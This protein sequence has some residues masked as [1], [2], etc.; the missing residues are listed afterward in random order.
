M[1]DVVTRPQK[2]EIVD[3]LTEKVK[4]T[5]HRVDGFKHVAVSFNDFYGDENVAIVCLSFDP[6]TNVREIKELRQLANSLRQALF[7]LNADTFPLVRV[8][9]T[10]TKGVKAEAK[11]SA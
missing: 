4:A 7:V 6:G 2:K 9:P 10:K 8:L 11:A 1:R 3:A 5:L